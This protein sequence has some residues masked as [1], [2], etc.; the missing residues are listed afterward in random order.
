MKST[1]LKLRCVIITVMA[2]VEIFGSL[3]PNKV[4]VQ[5]KPNHFHEVSRPVTVSSTNKFN[6]MLDP[7]E[8]IRSYKNM[9]PSAYS[10]AAGSATAAAGS[11]TASTV[12]ATGSKTS[13]AVILPVAQPK[14]HT[15]QQNK[16]YSNH[17]SDDICQLVYAVLCHIDPTITLFSRHDAHSKVTKFHETIVQNFDIKSRELGLNKLKIAKQDLYTSENALLHYVS[18]LIKKHFF[19][20]P[21][22]FRVPDLDSDDVVVINHQSGEY[23]YDQTESLR[24]C[25]KSMCQNVQTKLVKDIRE[26]AQTLM[27]PITKDDHDTGKKRMLLKNELIEAIQ[28]F[29]LDI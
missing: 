2:H 3:G 23:T 22:L 20:S 10:M 21:S 5:L 24:Q 18:R 16:L 19:M 6:D 9:P 29:I 7:L 4:M 12:C 8:L 25:M 15:T 14:P 11:A 17:P 1:Y 13:T 27:I 28:T 26:L